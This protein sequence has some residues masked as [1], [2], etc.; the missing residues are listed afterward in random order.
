MELIVRFT[1]DN[2]EK[3]LELQWSSYRKTTLTK[4]CRVPGPFEVVTREGVI[5][6][7]DGYLAIDSGGW[8]YPIDA[9]EHARTYELADKTT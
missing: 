6:C 3:G 2:L 1:R 5:E 4:M 8:P 9:E 7:Q